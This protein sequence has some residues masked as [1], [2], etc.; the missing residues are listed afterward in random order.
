[1]RFAAIHRITCAVLMTTV[2]VTA[3]QTAHASSFS[4]ALSQ[5][6][7][8]LNF[9]FRFENVDQDGIPNDAK[10]LTLK[11]RINY[12]SESFNDFHIFLEADDL[13]YIGE[14]KFNNGRNGEGTYPIVADPRG[15]DINQAFIGYGIADTTVK[16]GRQRINLDTQRFV[17][18]V[19]W[20]QNEQTYDALSIVN[21][22]ISN[23]TLTYI[24]IDQVNRILGPDDPAAGQQPKKWDSESYLFNAGIKVGDL[25]KLSLYGYYFDF[26][27][28]SPANS[29]K[30]L[31]I[32]FAG[33]RPIGAADFLYAVEY[34]DQQ[35]NG[36]NPNNY[37]ANYYNIEAGIAFA[38]L[39][40]K[41]GVENLEGD[42]TAAG[43]VFIT[44]LATA[45]KFQGWADKFLGHP[46]AGIEDSYLTL[47]GSPLGANV[48]LTLHSFDA[49]SG[50]ANYGSEWD[51]S[52]AKKL[53]DHFSLL[54]KF[55]S[56]DAD[57][58]A[59][60]TQKFWLMLTA[61]F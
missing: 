17:G 41:L 20:R 1:M 35:D 31:G 7:A 46:G 47:S 43:Q 52:I 48:A 49:D 12:K 55:A 8:H 9:R 28:E 32:R 24:F 33:K 25:G 4:D 27:D 21:N 39:T 22:S 42:S 6:T 54:V 29:N 50:S 37:S 60:D 18:G 15:T 36:D 14:A 40:I 23:T 51:L 38:P 2:G 34:A 11:T 44:P 16:L 56:Y 57:D 13:S 45:H 53:T 19:G 61:N 5:G 30:T 59:T 10:A 26:K 3:A 58:R